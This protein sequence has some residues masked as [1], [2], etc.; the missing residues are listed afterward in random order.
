MCIDFIDLNKACSKDSH[1]LLHIDYLV[2]NSFGYKLPSFMYSC[3]RYN[4]IR[5]VEEDIE[6]TSFKQKEKHIVTR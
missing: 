3:F 6:K 4:K 5:M 1:P 2:N